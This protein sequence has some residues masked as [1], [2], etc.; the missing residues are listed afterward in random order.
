MILQIAKLPPPIGGVTIHVKRLLASLKTVDN[1]EVGILDYSKER[2]VLGIIQKIINAKIV[3]LHV[4]KK[5][6]RLLLVLFFR[7]LNKKVI[8]TF[9]GNYNFQNILD[10]YSLKFSNAALLLNKISFNAASGIR[11]NKNFLIGAFIPPIE[12]DIVP[13]DEKLI[14]TIKEFKTNFNFVY[15]TNAFNYAIDA[16]GKE[17]YMGAELVSFFAKNKEK[18]LI[19]SDPSGNYY[20]HL[21]G[22]FKNL[23]ENVLFITQPHDFI[24]VIKVTDAL[25]RATTTDGDSLSVKEAL[26]YKKTVMATGVVDRPSDVL[27]FNNFDELQYLISNN[28][29]NITHS[30]VKNNFDDILKVYSNM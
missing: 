29:K 21:V 25:I 12:C 5:M 15:S 8:I 23:P 10:K 18:G 17:T 19:F 30:D 13:L 22:I 9:H 3:H 24:N 20:K 7:L 6:L 27:I 11:K 26:Y 2:N 4:T 28:T 14:T 1:M 16:Q